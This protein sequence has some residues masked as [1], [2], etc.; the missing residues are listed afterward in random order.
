VE[1][2]LKWNSFCAR[3]LESYKIFCE[4]NFPQN[5]EEWKGLSFN[6]EEENAINEMK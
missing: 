5:S 6:E 4:W 3:K 2:G 1:P